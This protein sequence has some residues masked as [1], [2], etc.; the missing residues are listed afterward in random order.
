MWLHPF[1]EVAQEYVSFNRFRAIESFKVPLEKTHRAYGRCLHYEYNNTYKIRL[2]THRARYRPRVKGRCDRQFK[3]AYYTALSIETILETLAHELA[4]IK[5]WEHS[6]AHHRL[7]CE[8]HLAFAD[9]CVKIGEKD[10]Q[11]PY[12]CLVRGKK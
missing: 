6:L 12:S 10:L 5:Y 7:T 8:L 3:A 9:V 2:L 1:L 11:R 4:H